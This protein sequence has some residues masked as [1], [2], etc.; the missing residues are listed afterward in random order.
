[1]ILAFQAKDKHQLV[2][3]LKAA[4]LAMFA[5]SHP[6]GPSGWAHVGPK[7][8]GPRGAHVG[9]KWVGPSG[10]HVG[11]KWVGPRGAQVGGPKP[12]FWDPKN[13]K[14][15]ILKI[16]IRSAQNV[17]KVWISRNKNPPDPIWA[18]LGPF[19]AWAGK[20]EKPMSA[21]FSLA[22]GPYSPGFLIW[23]KDVEAERRNP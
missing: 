13:P 16:Q 12:K 10:A 15:K 6:R 23:G 5:H 11:P 20:I 3:E 1:M 17:G 21:Y 4:I 9:P 8:V 2:I 14:I 19:F 22:H 18:H 7:W